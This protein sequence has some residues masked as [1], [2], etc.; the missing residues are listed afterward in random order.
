MMVLIDGKVVGVI[1]PDG[2]SGIKLVSAHISEHSED[3]DFAGE[4]VLDDGSDAQLPVP[5][6]RVQFAPSPYKIV[7]GRIV[8]L[9]NDPRTS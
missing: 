4:M 7:N 1:Y 5:G 6:L 2:D 8:R 3:P 9:P